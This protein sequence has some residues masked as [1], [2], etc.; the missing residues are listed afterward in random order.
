MIKNKLNEFEADWA[1]LPQVEKDELLKLKNKTILIS[2][3]SIARCLCYALLYQNDA[4]ALN[5]RV[6]FSD[7]DNSGIK[8]LSA[9]LALRGAFDFVDYNSLSEIRKAD[10]VIYTGMS[11]SATAGFTATRS[12]AGSTPKTSMP[13]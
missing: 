10:H 4:K 11:R 13:T 2:G 7:I 1:A 9:E 5:N 6:I 3:H 8:P 12:T